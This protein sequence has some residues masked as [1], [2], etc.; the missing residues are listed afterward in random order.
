MMRMRSALISGISRITV[1]WIIVVSPMMRVSCLGE[2]AR[3]T[4]QKRVP[5][6]PAMMTA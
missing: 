1:A 4:G 2:A 5:E 6:P 3:D